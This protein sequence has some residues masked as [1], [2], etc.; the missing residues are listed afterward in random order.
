VTGTPRN[1]LRASVLVP[2]LAACLFHGIPA[3]AGVNPPYVDL[4]LIPLADA[5]VIGDPAATRRL[6]VF[7]DPD[8]PYCAK[9]HEEI[10]KVVSR[11]PGIAFHVK[12]Y[13][14]NGSP[15]TYRK[16]VSIVCG[17]SVKLL[18]DS[19]A[20]RGVPP[21]AC[22]TSAVGD[23]MRLVH[24]LNI[25]STPSTV[26]PDGRVIYGYQEADTLLRLMAERKR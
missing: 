12:V 10:R 26:L 2:V 4:S 8:C 11:D 7:S 13:P 9:Y 1:S 23:T 17:K 6:I 25:A 16:A 19:Y 14:N 21:P 22:G 20:G 24:R 18:E 5:L 15:V 3:Y